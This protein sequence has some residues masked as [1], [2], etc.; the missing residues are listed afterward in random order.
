MKRSFRAAGSLV[1][2][3]R[4]P[5]AFLFTQPGPG[6]PPWTVAEYLPVLGASIPLLWRR[7][8]PVTRRPGVPSMF[9]T[10]DL[11]RRVVVSVGSTTK[12]DSVMLQTIGLA[13]FAS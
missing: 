7:R 3:I 2:A 6:R 9:A 1:R 8:A 11:K 10:R 5:P 13:A 12:G 4:R